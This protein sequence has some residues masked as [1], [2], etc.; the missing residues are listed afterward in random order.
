MID[1]R[2]RYRCTSC[3][4]VVAR[5][6]GVAPS[7]F[8][9]RCAVEIGVDSECFGPEALEHAARAVNPDPWQTPQA[10]VANIDINTPEDTTLVRWSNDPAL[11]IVRDGYGVPIGR[12]YNGRVYVETEDGAVRVAVVQ[13]GR[14]TIDGRLVTF[15]SNGRAIDAESS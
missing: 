8:C 13:D 5:N 15:D 9:V 2:E 6:P 12:M 3:Q 4:R 14:T 1:D 10:P 7:L 11:P